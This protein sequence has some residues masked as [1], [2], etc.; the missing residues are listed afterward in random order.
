MNKICCMIRIL[1]ITIVI[2]SCFASCKRD[3]NCNCSVS[4]SLKNIKP[5][6][7]TNNIGTRT[8]KEATQI[9]EEMSAVVRSGTVSTT[10][11]C[12]IE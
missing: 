1:I 8:K 2:L 7:S 6:T 9:C 5:S 10:I 4:S 11:T 12:K 3:Y